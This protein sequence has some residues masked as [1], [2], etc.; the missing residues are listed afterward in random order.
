MQGK[1]WANR[2]NANLATTEGLF[3]MITKCKTLLQVPEEMNLSHNF[4]TE[5][6]LRSLTLIN[7]LNTDTSSGM[8]LCEW[9]VLGR[10]SDIQRL[11][12]ATPPL[13]E[14]SC[15]IKW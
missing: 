13:N 8:C 5:K 2:M 6:E 10:K 3:D 15:P 4:Y 12:S 14:M 1:V 7:L 9:P 11:G